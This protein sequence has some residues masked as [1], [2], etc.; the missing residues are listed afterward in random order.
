[1]DTYRE[2]CAIRWATL[3]TVIRASDTWLTSDEEDASWENAKIINNAESPKQSDLE[4]LRLWLDQRSN[5][6]VPMYRDRQWHEL[7][8]LVTAKGPIEKL[9]KAIMPIT[10]LGRII[11]VSI[12]P[13]QPSPS[14]SRPLIKFA[15]SVSIPQC[16]GRQSPIRAL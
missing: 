15:A 4:Q 11:L 12:P 3:Q 14:S 7:R 10:R 5:E 16:S 6:Q 8:V 2:P 9:V 13:P 1:M